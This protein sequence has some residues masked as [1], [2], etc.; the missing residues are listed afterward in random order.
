[1]RYVEQMKNQ[2]TSYFGIKEKIEDFCL[3]KRNSVDIGQAID[4]AGEQTIWKLQ[5]TQPFSQTGQFG[6]MT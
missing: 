1:M 6:Q 5:N 2:E 3:V 4:L